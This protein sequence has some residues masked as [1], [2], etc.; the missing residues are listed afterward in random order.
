RAVAGG[1]DDVLFVIARA[2][3]AAGHQELALLVLHLLDDAA[4]GGAIHVY[5]ENVQKDTQA[6]APALGFDGH[7]FAVGGRDRDRP[8]RNLAVGIAEEIQADRKQE[9]HGGREPGSGEPKDKGPGGTE[10]E[11]VVDASGYDLQTTI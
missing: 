10:G 11:R 2:L 6:V 5:V 3:L 1:R 4:D 7:H 9:G 8:G